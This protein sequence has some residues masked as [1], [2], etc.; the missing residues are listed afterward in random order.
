MRIFKQISLILFTA[1]VLSSCMPYMIKSESD[2]ATKEQQ[3]E[4]KAQVMSL[5]KEEYKQPFKLED[6]NYKYDTHWKHIDCQIAGYC[7]KVRYGTYSFKIQ[8]VDNPIITMKFDIDDENKYSIK[9]LIEYF[10]NTQLKERYCSAFA[11]YYGDITNGNKLPLEPYTSETSKFCDGRNQTSFH[12]S[13]DYYLKHKD[14][15]K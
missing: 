3:E 6:F 13:R 2:G 5:L 7:P 10:K 9:D 12:L 15:Y 11:R 1:I 4:V 8:A 14:E